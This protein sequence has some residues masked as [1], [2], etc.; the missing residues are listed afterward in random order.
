M[1]TPLSEGY[2]CLFSRPFRHHSIN[3]LLKGGSTQKGGLGSVRDARGQNQGGTVEGTIQKK[4]S[5]KSASSGSDRIYG[6]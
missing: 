4:K 2:Q 6:P 1:V 3:G 5:C